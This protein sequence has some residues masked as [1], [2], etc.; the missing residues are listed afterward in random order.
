MNR[1][2]LLFGQTMDMNDSIWGD[3]SMLMSEG[4]LLDEQEF[5][6]EGTMDPN[7]VSMSI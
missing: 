3:D 4:S 1:G 2:R 7:S 6:D 5:P